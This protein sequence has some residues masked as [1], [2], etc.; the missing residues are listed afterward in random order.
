MNS[1]PLIPI[2]T[3]FFEWEQ[4]NTRFRYVIE[5]DFPPDPLHLLKFR[6]LIQQIFT[7]TQIL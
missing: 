7:L 5:L 2:Y 6:P 1:T 4:I 3:I